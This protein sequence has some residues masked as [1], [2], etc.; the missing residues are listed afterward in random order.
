ME[1]QIVI[2]YFFADEI[3]KASHLYDDPQDPDCYQTYRDF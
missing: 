2:F 3:L 1:L